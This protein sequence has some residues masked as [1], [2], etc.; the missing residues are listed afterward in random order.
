MVRLRLFIDGRRD[1][2]KSNVVLATVKIEG[3]VGNDV[4]ITVAIVE[5]KEDRSTLST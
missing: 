4:E 1:V 5:T 2:G 3:H